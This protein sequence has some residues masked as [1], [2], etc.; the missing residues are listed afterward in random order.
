M[1]PIIKKTPPIPK[2]EEK[3]VPV[4]VDDWGV[5]GASDWDQDSWGTTPTENVDLDKLIQ[6]RNEILE[7]KESQG[8]DAKAK[9]RIQLTTYSTYFQKKRKKRRGKS[10]I[11]H[12]LSHLRWKLK[13]NLN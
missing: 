4:K 1:E 9:P 10:Q 5:S 11:S 13:R 6:K 12:T 7:Q 3:K 8:T 2:I